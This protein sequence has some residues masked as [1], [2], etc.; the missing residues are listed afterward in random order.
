MADLTPTSPP[1]TSLGEYVDLIKQQD[2]TLLIALHEGGREVFD[3]IEAIRDK[4]GING[5]LGELL[6]DHVRHGW[7]EVLPEEVGALTSA[8]LVSDHV[9]R[10]NL[11]ELLDCGHIYWNPG[12]QVMDEIAELRREGHVLFAGV[13]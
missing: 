8:V 4:L 2:G 10:D 11:G 1:D 5:A 13:S 9:E 7:V 12:Y 3:D 6:A